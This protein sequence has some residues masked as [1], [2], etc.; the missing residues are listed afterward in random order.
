M[1][2]LVA[3]LFGADHGLRRHV[4]LRLGKNAEQAGAGGIVEGENHVEIIGDTGLA[5][6]SGRSGPR[7]HVGR[8][9]CLQAN[10][11]ET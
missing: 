5:L 3:G 11:E 7:D 8:A 9:G 10:G 4:K 1:A 2:A 6:N